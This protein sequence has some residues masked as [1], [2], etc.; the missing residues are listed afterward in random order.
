MPG[1]AEGAAHLRVWRDFQVVVDRVQLL[2]RSLCLRHGI[3]R[4]RVAQREPACLFAPVKILAET[5]EVRVLGFL[6]LDVRRVGQHH[7]EQVAGGAR[8]KNAS[9]EA[10]CD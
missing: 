5:V 6:F 10:E 4:R 7:R 2:Q 3:Q 9:P 8:G 1:V